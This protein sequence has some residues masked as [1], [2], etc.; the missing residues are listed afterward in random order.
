M[1]DGVLARGGVAAAV[2]D[3]GVAAGD[4]RRRGGARPRAAAARRR[5]DRGGLP[6]G[7]LRRRRAGARR[8][9]RAATRS[10]RWSR[11]CASARAPRRT[12]ARR[13]RTS[14]TPPR[15]SSRAPRARRC[16]PTCAR[17]ERSAAGLARTH[18]ETPM[19][20]RTLLQQAVP[21]TFGLKA[22]GWAGA[23]RAAGDALERVELAAQLGGPA[24]TLDGLGPD[25]LER[26]AAELGLAAPGAAVAHRPDPDRRAR[27]RARH[28]LRRD[29]EG[30]GRRRPARPDRGRRGERGGARRLVL[31]AAQAQPGRRDLRARL[32]PPGAGPRREPARGDGARA[33]A[34]GRR[35]ARGVGAA[36]L[37]AGQHRIGGGLAAH[38]PRGP[39]GPP[40]AHARQPRRCRTGVESA[41]ASAAAL[42]DRAYPS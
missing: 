33:R 12:G 6:R 18:R 41:V 28:G 32:R 31:D 38:V 9:P 15:C 16:S 24:G 29:R 2:S 1:F 7:A 27:R 13:A 39:P 8:R 21:I 4:A 17:A 19:I 14:S 40:R 37:A 5:G 23:L 34:R 11:R 10:C 22:A 42:V 30:R 26:F 36:A 25:V 35:L 20:G 3:D